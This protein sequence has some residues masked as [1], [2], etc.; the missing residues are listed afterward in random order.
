MGLKHQHRVIGGEQDWWW[1]WW[2]TLNAYKRTYVRTYICTY[3]CVCMSWREEVIVMSVYT[4]IA[5]QVSWWSKRLCIFAFLPNGHR[6]VFDCLA[7]LSCISSTT[8]IPL[9][10]LWHRRLLLILGNSC[11]AS[12]WW[13]FPVNEAY[14]LHPPPPSP[15]PHLLQEMPSGRCRSS[16]YLFLTI[17]V[18]GN[19]GKGKYQWGNFF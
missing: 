11:T 1:W 14:V 15:M 6:E 9:S 13:N 2:P 7:I 12:L 3:V 17:E 10:R 18:Y 19:M 5:F 16:L 4:L 8:L